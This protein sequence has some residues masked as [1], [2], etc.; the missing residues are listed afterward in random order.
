MWGEQM[1]EEFIPFV[2]RS[3]TSKIYIENIMLI[4]QERRKIIILTEDNK[5]SWYGKIGEL[6]EYLDNR[7]L[8]CHSSYIINM[9]KVI[10]MREQTIFFE[11]GYTIMVG[12]DKFVFAKQLFARYIQTKNKHI[13]KPYIEAREMM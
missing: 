11:N 13:R 12:R 6:S 2:N 1:R 3:E 10:R 9:D 8:K 7:F 5:Y 4:E